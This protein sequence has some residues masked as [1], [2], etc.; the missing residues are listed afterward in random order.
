ME[1]AICYNKVMDVIKNKD[2]S[3]AAKVYL[4]NRRLKEKN[5]NL[6]EHNR[7]LVNLLS[8]KRYKLADS[9]VNIMHKMIHRVGKKELVVAEVIKEIEQEEKEEEE[10]K[11]TNV[12]R[13]IIRGKVDIINMNFYHWDG[14]AV[15]RG[16]AE[17]YIYDL[18]CLLKEIGLTP[19]ILQC[20]KKPFKK[21]YR[22]IDVVG[23]GIGD[24]ITTDE[25]SATFNDYCKDCEFIIASPLSLACEIKDVP[26]IGINHGVNFDGPWNVYEKQTLGMSNELM[27]ALKNTIKCVCVDTNFIN[28][29][30]TQDYNITAK[31]IYIPNYY[32]GKKF[33]KNKTKNK[34][35]E[36][37]TFMYPR[38]DYESGGS[39][40]L[41][42]AF[43]KILIKYK[44]KIDLKIVGQI[45]NDEVGEKLKKFLADFPD[46]VSH[47]EY[48]MDEMAGVYEGVDVVLIPTKYSEGTSLSCIEAM[49]SGITVLTTYVGGLSNLVIDGFNGK[50]IDPTAEAL[51]EGV[52]ELIDNPELRKTL[53]INGA[54]VA[55]AAFNKEKW[56]TKWKKVIIEARENIKTLNEC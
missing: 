52:E 6:L 54:K 27:R 41:I 38:R 44:G 25:I 31:E 28:W 37:L 35:M 46:S 34:K 50:L 10:E 36:K 15:F 7:E 51:I 14:E 53:A 4:E 21:K 9:I 19:R 3:W 20:S 5:N 30:R 29:T 24:G 17:R 11:S 26:V 47:H 45:D 22:G 40:I 12:K 1:I 23:L 16:G 18:A 43:R 39:D 56:E 2:E 33:K 42:E 55:E 49:A 48:D 8:I 13:K 32:D